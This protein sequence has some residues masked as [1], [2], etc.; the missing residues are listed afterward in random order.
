MMCTQLHEWL[1]RLRDGLSDENE[2][3][4]KLN[5][6]PCPRCKTSIEKNQGCMHMTCSQCRYEFCWLCMG[7]YQKHT[8]ETGKGL[9]NSY[10]DVAKLNR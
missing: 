6:K 3:W 4:K 9:C 7:D 5:T 8:S 10:E 2:L 1:D